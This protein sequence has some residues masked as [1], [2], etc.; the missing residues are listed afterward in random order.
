[1]GQIREDTFHSWRF[2]LGRGLG[3]GGVK[4][5]GSVVQDAIHRFQ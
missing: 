2:R 1:M 3:K 4:D 5:I